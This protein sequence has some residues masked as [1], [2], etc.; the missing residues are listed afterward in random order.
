M[1]ASGLIGLVE[2]SSPAASIGVVGSEGQYKVAMDPRAYGVAD[3]S[4]ESLLRLARAPLRLAAGGKDPN[5]DARAD[6]ADRSRGA[7][8]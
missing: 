1:K 2:P 7:P 4:I 6:E 3:P 5:G 8:V